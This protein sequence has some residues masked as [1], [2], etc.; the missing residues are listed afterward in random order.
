MML[1][2]Q[3]IIV[4]LLFFIITIETFKFKCEAIW[5]DDL[6]SQSTSLAK[7]A[8]GVDESKYIRSF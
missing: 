4:K 8:R 5:F 3:K 2:K 1:F 7:S 6:K